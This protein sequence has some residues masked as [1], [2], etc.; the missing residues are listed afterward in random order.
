MQAVP[1]RYSLSQWNRF[2]M[3]PIGLPP[4][5][6]EPPAPAVSGR[7]RGI[8][9]FDGVMSAVRTESIL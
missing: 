2:W 1:I 8:G 9:T 4:P 5:E 7:G 6:S 3:N